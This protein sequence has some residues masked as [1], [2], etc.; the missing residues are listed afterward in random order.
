M[1][2]FPKEEKMLKEILHWDKKHLRTRTK[3]NYA[4]TIDQLRSDRIDPDSHRK[5]IVTK[6]FL[7]RSDTSRSFQLGV[8]GEMV[9][10]WVNRACK[11]IDVF[12]ERHD[13]R[14]RLHKIFREDSLYEHME[15]LFYTV[16]A[17]FLHSVNFF[18]Y[19]RIDNEE[20]RTQA[21]GMIESLLMRADNLLA[22]YGSYLSLQG[23]SVYPD[24]AADLAGIRN[25]VAAM[26]E[27]FRS[28][29]TL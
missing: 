7:F 28:A 25:A 1:R 3:V 4:L 13:M 9:R 23:T 27:A 5:Y 6:E 8:Y 26:Q 20:Y 10:D 14:G 19:D 12:H 29:D 22:L 11:M 2:R 15:E 16:M 18:Q 21:G 24:T 17:Q